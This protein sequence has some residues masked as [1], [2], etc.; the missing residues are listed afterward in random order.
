M[1]VEQKGKEWGKKIFLNRGDKGNTPWKWVL[2]RKKKKKWYIGN[3]LKC[4]KI[5]ETEEYEN[6]EKKRQVR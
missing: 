4:K 3:S 2:K 1:T 6:P 5:P